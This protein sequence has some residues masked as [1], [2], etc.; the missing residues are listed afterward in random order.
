M[1]DNFLIEKT[2]T[3]NFLSD[4]NGNTIHIDSKTD[5]FKKW[6]H[7]ES[8]VMS[9]KGPLTVKWSNLQKLAASW[10]TQTSGH[11]N[12]DVSLAN[13]FKNF[14]SYHNNMWYLNQN[15]G[16]YDLPKNPTIIDVGTGTATMNMFIHKYLP[17]SKFYLVD[18]NQWIIND[19]P[20]KVRSHDNM[21]WKHD[22]SVVEDCITTTGLD[23]NNFVFLNQFDDWNFESDLITSSMAWGMH[24]H[25]SDYW[26]RCVDSLKI[27]GKLMLDINSHW[28]KS[29]TKEIDEAFG[30]KHSVVFS[31]S[32]KMVNLDYASTL[33][34]LQ[35]HYPNED[36]DLSTYGADVVATRCVWTR[37]R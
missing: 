6:N 14:D 9:D 29:A 35:K 34:R 10:L 8:I 31:F 18:R 7:Y 22:W 25:K 21:C 15:F 37:R 12:G 17:N 30:C 3:D 11:G 4:E 24:F 33:E 2:M 16:I 28:L 27:G 32:R 23:R 26:Q 1:T 36:Y 19:N 13:F 5:Y 20:N